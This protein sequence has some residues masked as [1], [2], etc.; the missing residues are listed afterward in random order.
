MGNT[1]NE[2]VIFS[3]V[4]EDMTLKIIMMVMDD[5]SNW[6]KRMRKNKKRKERGRKK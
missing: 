2:R 4:T 3:F 5:K 1:E 6:C